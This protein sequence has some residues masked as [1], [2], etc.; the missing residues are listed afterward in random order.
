MI[1]LVVV[2]LSTYRMSSFWGYC[3]DLLDGRSKLEEYS[4]GDFWDYMSHE[5]EILQWRTEFAGDL[6]RQGVGLS[7][8]C[9][10]VSRACLRIKDGSHPLRQFMDVKKFDVV[11][12][13]AEKLLPHLLALVASDAQK[14]KK[15]RSKPGDQSHASMM[16]APQAVGKPREEVERH[17]REVHAWLQSPDSPLRQFL[18]AASDGGIFFTANVHHKAAVSYVWHRK[19]S[20][21]T[22]T[23]GVGVQD[24]VLAAQARLCD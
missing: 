8:H 17:A 24:F 7:R 18:S 19:L 3:L 23:K 6:D 15:S 12:K 2:N 21:Q 10:I 9:Q 1:L 4:F 16:S 22:P 20:E 14:K 11:V 5:T 13:E